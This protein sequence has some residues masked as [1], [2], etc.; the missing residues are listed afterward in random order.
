MVEPAGAMPDSD[1][2]ETADPALPPDIPNADP[3]AEEAAMDDDAGV[4]L[5]ANCLGALDR[6]EGIAGT[7][8][9]AC[10]T[11][12]LIVAHRLLGAVCS[13]SLAL[14]SLSKLPDGFFAI[15]RVGCDASFSW[16]EL[17][18]DIKVGAEAFLR[19][20]WTSVN[21]IL[22]PCREGA[23]TPDSDAKLGLRAPS[24]P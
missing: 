24:V 12:C 22:E 15:A 9:V 23:G 19:R 13:E 2:A 16:D 10:E 20:F 4:S 5:G 6:F 1:R 17:E 21:C 8:G 18:W 7:G 14:P 3:Y 11:A